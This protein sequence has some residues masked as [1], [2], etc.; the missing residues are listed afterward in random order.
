MFFIIHNINICHLNCIH[1]VSKSGK[2][3][4]TKSRVSSPLFKQFILYLVT[5]KIV[6]SLTFDLWLY[7]Y[8]LYNYEV[9]D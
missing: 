6:E 4:E 7:E 1:I 9:L 5:W 8:G 2:Q 3:A